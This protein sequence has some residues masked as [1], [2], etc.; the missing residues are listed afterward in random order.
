MLSDFYKNNK[1]DVIWWIEDLDSVGE[2]L[3][4]FDKK[5]IFNLFKDY[6]YN[7]TDEQIAIFNQ[8]NPYWKKFFSNRIKNR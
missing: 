1:S 8:E 5:K 7:L 2:F 3:F 6:P 4:S